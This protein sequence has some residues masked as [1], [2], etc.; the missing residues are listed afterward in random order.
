MRRVFVPEG[1]I[2]GDCVRLMGREAHYVRD[3]L[4][5]GVGAHFS[6]VLPGG[7]ERVA[8]VQRLAGQ[9]VEAAL[10]E[11]RDAQADPRVDVRVRPALVKARRLDLVVQK[12]TELGATEV[13]P[14]LCERGVARP[15]RD[16][17]PHKVERWEKIA[18]EAARQCGRTWAPR[19]AEPVSFPLAVREVADLGGT[20]LV[21]APAGS[22]L[23]QGA[24]PALDDPE[25][26]SV[27]VGPEGGFTPDEVEVARAA[28]LRI[29]S[30]GGRILR[31]ETAAIA[32]CALLMLELGE[33]A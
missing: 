5:L 7:I 21:L 19:V 1:G 30:L 28:G 2:E 15:D 3:V 20:G 32:A 8:T 17:V 18:Q 26:I 27:F 16:R 11:P 23:V 4:R 10:G 24:L 12:C 22:G 31:A 25:P 33:F 13:G 29:I 14:V 6:A 9:T